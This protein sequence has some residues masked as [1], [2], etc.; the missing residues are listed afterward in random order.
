MFN[1][2]IQ[3]ANRLHQETVGPDYKLSKNRKV[4]SKLL[5]LDIDLVGVIDINSKEISSKG[6]EKITINYNINNLI[7][8]N[9]W[10]Q[11]NSITDKL[12]VQIKGEITYPTFKLQKIVLQNTIIIKEKNKI[13]NI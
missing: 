11:L 4:Y 9:G 13:L 12:T 5:D 7:N 10:F 2:S 6:D 8:S 1:I 3:Q